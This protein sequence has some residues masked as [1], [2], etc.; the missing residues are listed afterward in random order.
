MRRV[1]RCNG[2]ALASTHALAGLAHGHGDPDIDL[3]FHAAG[4]EVPADARWRPL[5]GCT[6]A[7][8]AS[9]DG[10]G[11]V[12]RLRYEDRPR[13]AE[14]VIGPAG[15]SIDVYLATHADL[16][17]V[18]ELL[19]TQV[20]SCAMSERGLTCLHAGVIRVAGRVALLVGPTG[21]GKSTTTAAVARHGHDV[22][23]DDVAAIDL[24]PAGVTVLPGRSRVRLRSDAAVAVAGDARLSPVW[25]SAVRGAAKDRLDFERAPIDGPV[26]VTALYVLARHED[27]AA[28][29]VAS[30]LDGIEALALLMANRHLADLGTRAGRARD[31]AVLGELVRTVPTRML[32]RAHGLATLD[33]TVEALI[34]DVTSHG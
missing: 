4:A 18:I 20:L 19:L 28:R 34:A 23:C 2:F 10:S 26:P 6:G 5:T 24:G 29:P 17:E 30:A 33:A 15:A 13:W 3:R 14:F 21:S 7:W 12:L 32:A 22:L 8:R 1:Y 31:F 11:G 16:E 27:P 25:R 9:D